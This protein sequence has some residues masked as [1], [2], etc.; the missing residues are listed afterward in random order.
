MVRTLFA[1]WFLAAAVA[2]ASPLPAGTYKLHDNWTGGSYSTGLLLD[3]LFNNTNS[4]T[5]SFDAPGADARLEYSGSTIRIFGTVYGG[6][7]WGTGFAP[8]N[9]PE[10][11]LGF[12]TIDFRYNVGVSPVAGDV[13]GFQDVQV[14]GS[15]QNF[16][17]ISGPGGTRYLT[18]QA[19]GQNLAL[20]FGDGANGG[21]ITGFG[22]LAYCASGNDC[23]NPVHID[24]QDW[25][26]T[27]EAVPEPD[28]AVLIVTALAGL[29]LLRRRN[30]I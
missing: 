9:W 1:T 23:N 18:D 19:N 13:G 16:G 5:F 25:N 8:A 4:Y 29:G 20:R 24:F 17:S 22:W 15:Y 10:S 6:M 28:S 11:Y 21:T 2:S 3:H 12:Y 27:A 14:Q 7:D 26:F 30:M